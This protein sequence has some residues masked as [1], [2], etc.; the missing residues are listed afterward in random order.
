MSV[1]IAILVGYAEV[2]RLRRGLSARSSHYVLNQS[3]D[4]GWGVFDAR[5]IVEGVNVLGEWLNRFDVF[6]GLFGEFRKFLGVFRE[7]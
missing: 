1:A 7:L 3:I 5:H 2:G 4:W 6:G